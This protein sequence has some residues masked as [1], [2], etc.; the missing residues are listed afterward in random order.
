MRVF[1]VRHGQTDWNVLQRAQGGADRP[2]DATGRAQTAALAGAFAEVPLDRLWSSPLLRAAETA[3]ALAEV[4]GAELVTDARLHERRF[5]E[6]EGTTYAELRRFFDSRG[7]ADLTRRNRTRPPGGESFADVWERLLPFAAEML[8]GPPRQA[9]VSHGGVQSLLCA[10]LL[11]GVLDDSNAYR[12]HN[13]SI[14]ELETDPPR[15]LRN[16]EVV[17]LEAIPLLPGRGDVGAR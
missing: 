11:G 15:L 7:G 16:D 17:H 8:A 9:V 4:T 12:F 13:A 2:L 14:T 10:M 1:L 3:R 5:G 6:L